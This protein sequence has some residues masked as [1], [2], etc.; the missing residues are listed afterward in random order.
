M[1]RH[2]F[3]SGTPSGTTRA[4]DARGLVTICGEFHVDSRFRPAPSSRN[5]PGSA[6][7]FETRRRAA[8]LAAHAGTAGIGSYTAEAWTDRARACRHGPAGVRRL[9]GGRCGSAT[10]D[11]GGASGSVADCR[12]GRTGLAASDAAR[13]RRSAGTSRAAREAGAA[14]GST[15]AIGRFGLADRRY[16]GLGSKGRMGAAA[17]ARPAS[18]ESWRIRQALDTTAQRQPR[19]RRRRLRRAVSDG[20]R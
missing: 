10:A 16:D 19:T 15:A 5:S 18:I 13:R 6:A 12:D 9:G 11:S 17:P 8:L 1:E 4:A 2:N 20:S 3:W 14:C 7:G